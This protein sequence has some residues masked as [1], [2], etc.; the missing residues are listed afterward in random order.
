MKILYIITGLGVGGA[1]RQVLDLADRFSDQGHSVE[2]C[3]LTGPVLLQPKNKS[4][5]LIGLELGKSVVGFVKG[6]LNLRA[7]IKAFDPDVVHAHM[8][9]ANLFSRVVRLICPIKRLVNTA[10]STNEGGRVRMLAYR[11]THP[12]VDVSTNVTLEAVKVFEQK[13]ACPIGS[14]QAV[15]NGIDT[16]LFKPDSFARNLIRT[17]ECISDHEE[18]IVAVGRLVD[19]KDYRNLLNA[20]N[21]LSKKRPNI[22]LWIVGDGPERKQLDDLVS[23]LGIDHLVKFLGVR[24]DVSRVYN[25][26]DLYVL[27]SAWEGFGLVVAEAMASECVVVVTDCGGVKEVVGDFGFVAPAK[28]SSALFNAMNDALSLST[29]SA[30]KMT[31]AARDRIVNI[32]SIDKI[33]EKWSDIYQG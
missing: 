18:L 26:A 5:K 23:H 25:A 4:V 3:Y 22:K 29:E 17:S 14:M 15:S 1:E 6:V 33:V 30:E 11:L 12:L 10:H 28:N 20:F 27:S 24:S 21:N 7:I 19:A 31:K 8:L 13:K 9:H 2:I 16:E 32:Y